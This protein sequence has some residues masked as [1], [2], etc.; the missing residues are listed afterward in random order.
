MLKLRFITAAKVAGTLLVVY[1]VV[2]LLTWLALKTAFKKHGIPFPLRE[3][4]GYEL[5]SS[6]VLLISFYDMLRSCQVKILAG[7]SVISI[8]IAF[9]LNRGP[10]GG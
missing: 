3:G 6:V 5:P 10:K 7:I 1:F 4:F 2:R 8:A 9:I